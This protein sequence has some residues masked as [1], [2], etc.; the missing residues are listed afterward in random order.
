MYV[1]SYIVAA[2]LLRKLGALDLAMLTSDRA[3]TSAM[4]GDSDAERALTVDQVVEGLLRADQVTRNHWPC[5]S[6]THRS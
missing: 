6:G 2:K 1:S 3:A 4:E 5:H